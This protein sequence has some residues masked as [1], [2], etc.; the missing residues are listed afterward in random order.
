MKQLKFMLAAATAVGIAAAAQASYLSGSTDFESGTVASLFT[1]NGAAAEPNDENESAIVEGAAEG[2]AVGNNNFG[3]THN[4]K[5]EVNTG[6]TPILRRVTGSDTTQSLANGNVYIDTLVKFT[7]TP[8]GD[9]PEATAEDKLMIYLKED[10]SDSE[11]PVTNLVAIAGFYG[12]TEFAGDTPYVLT[13]GDDDIVP[14]KWYRLTVSA[15]GNIAG[16]LAQ[17]SVVPAFTIKI[18]GVTCIAD[19]K[20]YDAANEAAQ[21]LFLGSSMSEDIEKKEI[22]L[23]RV[24]NDT[25][26]K[27]V[28]FAG[29]GEVDDLVISTFDPSKT[30]V[31]FTLALADVPDGMG[32][33]TYETPIENGTLDAE[34]KTV[35][36]YSDNCTVTVDYTPV[37]NYT[38]TWSATGADAPT[39]NTFAPVDNA[40][41]TLT[42]AYVAPSPVDFTYTFKLGDGVSSVTYTIGTADSV[43][44][45]EDTVV[46]NIVKD[47]KILVE[48]KAKNW[49]KIVGGTGPYTV[50]EDKT[51]SVTATDASGDIVVPVPE[52]TNPDTVNKIL[53]WAKKE[54]MTPA[55]VTNADTLMDNYLLNVTD[56]NKAPQ[57]KIVE[58]DLSGDAPAVKAEITEADGTTK[59][60][61]LTSDAI[62]GTVK[63]KVAT[64]LQNL[65]SADSV[66][67]I[68]ASADGSQFIR[69][70][71]E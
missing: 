1:Y 59:I 40:A 4:F 3:D 12:A 5:L 54:N 22:L 11:N 2:V 10:L 13:V 58:I 25:T 50:T 15:I 19:K 33:V 47:S 27:A 32:N 20:I 65:D 23:S 62:N 57:I 46:P 30:V 67:E 36:C 16:S 24:Q 66:E 55:D 43:T 7:V 35:Y 45:Y 39:S 9:T 38:A 8:D 71:V 26:L 42:F 14:N 29:E 56:L 51:I 31:D 48:A 52:G 34:A 41:Y 61:D 44:I 28:G 63:Y 18:D 17:G 70:V 49:Y 53:A 60:K 68:P 6:T 21:L 64:D 37:D 69:V